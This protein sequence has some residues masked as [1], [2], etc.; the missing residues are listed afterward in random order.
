[1][2]RK[3]NYAI[4]IYNS[5]NYLIAYKY[6][7]QTGNGDDRIA[8][9]PGNDMLNGN[10]GNDVIQGDSGNDQISGGNGN[11]IL[12]GGSG[13]DHFNCGAGTDAITDFQPGVDTKTANCENS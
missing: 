7:F 4:V 8:G 13:K 5:M 2:H 12:T 11:D 6:T 9:S 3:Y 10:A 1:M